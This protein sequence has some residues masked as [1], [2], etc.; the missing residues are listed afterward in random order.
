MSIAIR[1]N[2]CWNFC[3]PLCCCANGKCLQMFYVFLH[4]TLNVKICLF[5][6]LPTSIK[7]RKTLLIASGFQDCRIICFEVAI[8]NNI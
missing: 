5:T 1:S 7:K 8:L 2:L 4:A 6:M 3:G